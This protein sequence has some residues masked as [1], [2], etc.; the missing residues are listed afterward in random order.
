MSSVEG[1]GARSLSGE[2]GGGYIG[3]IEGISGMYRKRGTLVG[4]PLLVVG[5]DRSTT[6][7]LPTPMPMPPGGSQHMKDNGN[8]LRQKNQEYL[9]RGLR[10]RKTRDLG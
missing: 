4:C 3:C 7:A 6:A 9:S 5:V 1:Q 10:G 2:N 8:Y